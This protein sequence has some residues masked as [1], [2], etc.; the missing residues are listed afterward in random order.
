MRLRHDCG[1][2][3]ADVTY[4][5]YNPDWTADQ[6]TVSERPN[7]DM[8]SYRAW[9][10]ANGAY[11]PLAERTGDANDWH[12]RTYTW[13]CKCGAPPIN[14]RHERISEMWRQHVDRPEPLVIVLLADDR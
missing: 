13:R 4:E 7:V 6:L 10:E 8:D 5:E 12:A 9:H 1:R 14:R 3:L 11:V 2:N